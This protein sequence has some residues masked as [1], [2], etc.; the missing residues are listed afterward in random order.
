MHRSTTLMLLACLGGSLFATETEN[1]GIL[2]AP[3]PLVIDGDAKDWDLSGGVFVCSDVEN[4]RGRSSS[5]FHLEYGQG[6]VQAFVRNPDV[7]G[8]VQWPRSDSPLPQP[9][10]G[11]RWC[12]STIGET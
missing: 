7:K 10:R 5:W 6:G 8:Y 2:P 1:F 12:H 4:L 11:S 3:K 9:G